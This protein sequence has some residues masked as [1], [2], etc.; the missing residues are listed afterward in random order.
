MEAEGVGV[1]GDGG[2]V[3]G[4]DPGVL[5]DAEGLFGGLLGIVKQ[6]IGKF[7]RTEGAVAFVAAV[8]EGFGGDGKT[9]GAKFVEHQGTG[10]SY[11]D[12]VGASATNAMGDSAGDFA[13]AGGLVV[14]RAMGFHVMDGGFGF[15]GDAL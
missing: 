10:E 4:D 12:G 7:A 14:E 15:S 13:S 8:G 11:E 9:G 5:G 2:V 3:G 1:E 6:S